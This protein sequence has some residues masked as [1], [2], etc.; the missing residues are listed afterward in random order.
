MV[1]T[2]EQKRKREREPQAVEGDLGTLAWLDLRA[3]LKIPPCINSQK[4]VCSR[5]LI[6]HPPVAL[7]FL[8]NAIPWERREIGEKSSYIFLMHLFSFLSLLCF[9][10]VPY[11]ASSFVLLQTIT[12]KKKF[13]FYWPLLP[14]FL[15][16]G[17]N[18]P[19]T[20]VPE[21]DA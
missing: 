10:C 12:L 15:K 11:Q 20:F 14:N 7:S 16:E 4:D 6:S 1:G 17:K 13:W 9:C 2:E 21:K 8:N 18:V 3:R 5:G 19:F